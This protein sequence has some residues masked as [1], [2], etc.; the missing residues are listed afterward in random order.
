MSRLYRSHRAF[1]YEVERTAT[2]VILKTDSG[3]AVSPAHLLIEVTPEDAQFEARMALAGALARC[4][5]LGLTTE[6]AVALC[7]EVARHDG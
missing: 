3:L 5:F 7:Q 4:R 6:D 1:G 2:H